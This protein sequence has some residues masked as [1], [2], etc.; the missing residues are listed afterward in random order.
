MAVL[1]DG[2]SK[3]VRAWYRA[4]IYRMYYFRM[5]IEHEK[6]S[7]TPQARHL[8]RKLAQHTKYGLYLKIPESEILQF[9]VD[10]IRE[11]KKRKD[12]KSIDVKVIIEVLLKETVVNESSPPTP[13]ALSFSG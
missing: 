11:I 3:R 1:L 2:K 8:D 7:T 4:H 6:K 5:L 13:L 9:Q 12:Y 10:I